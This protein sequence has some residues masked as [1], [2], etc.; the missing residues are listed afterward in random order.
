MER[1]FELFDQIRPQDLFDIALLSAVIYWLLNLIKGTRTIPILVGMTVLVGVYVLASFLKLD[2]IGWLM[3][4]L[5]SSAV[6]IMVVLFQGDIRTALARLGLTTMFRE[7]AD[8]GRGGLID[9]V[10]STAY[11]L[12]SRRIGGTMV[13]EH[14]TGLRHYIERG[15]PLNALLSR[16][17]LESIFA[18]TS[19]LHDGAVIITREG[20]VAAARC[21]LPLSTRPRR[22]FSLGTRHRSALGVSEETDAPV[23]VVSEERG[24]VSLAFN[25]ELTRD[26]EETEL[27]KLLTQILQ[28]Y[29]L[30]DAS[31]KPHPES[32]PAEG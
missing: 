7:T 2:A 4:N 9:E 8:T 28:G 29:E 10:V 6:I 5:F 27:R 1:I 32:Q 23:V 11:S 20:Q 15:T 22:G 19:P 13:L 26:L 24:M 25:G 3:D 18:P 21:I 12:S 16:E 17:L 30:K 14:E 31:T